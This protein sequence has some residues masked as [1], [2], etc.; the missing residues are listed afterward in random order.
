M[1]ME[2]EFDNPASAI[3][4]FGEGEFGLESVGAAFDA[5]LARGA[6]VED[7][8]DAVETAR[9]EGVIDEAQRAQLDR[10]IADSMTVY[11]GD[12]T[13]A[14]V[15]DTARDPRA[16]DGDRAESRTR[17]APPPQRGS[18]EAP[19]IGPGSRLRDR[20]II[21]E[22]LG[23]GGMGTVY[24][25][26]DGLKL[27]ARDRN[28]YLAIKVLNDSFARRPDAFIALQREASRQQRLAHPN[29]ATVFDFD[30]SGGTMFITMELLE[31]RTLDRF[32]RS[33]VRPR[34]GLP[35][36]RAMPIIEQMCAAL[37]H[38]HQRGIVHADFKPGNCF[39]TDHGELKVLD[40]GIARAMKDPAGH[41]A[42]Q[43]LF[44]PRSMGALTPAYASPEML[45]DSANADPRDDLYALGCVAYELITGMHPFK[46]VPADQAME[47]GMVPER[48]KSL[49]RR[50][51]A[52]L[53]RALAF[54][55]DARI[56][57]AE[58]FLE[59]LGS[60]RRAVSRRPVG[61]AAAGLVTV[62]LTGMF[63]VDYLRD[64]P[65]RHLRQAL[66]SQQSDAVL[67][68]LARVDEL[69]PER[70]QPILVAHRLRLLEFFEGRYRA[71]TGL[72][73]REIQFAGVQTLL[74]AAA[75]LFP[76]S[77]AVRD[78]QLD[79]E[80]LRA[81]HVSDL[82]GRF[83]R[84]L[85]PEFLVPSETG[86]DLHDLLRELAEVAPRHPLLSDVR[87][88][89][90]YAGSAQQ[91]LEAG[92]LDAAQ[93]IVDSGLML[94]VDDPALRD[95]A[96]RIGAARE[97]AGRRARIASLEDEIRAQAGALGAPGDLAQLARLRGELESLAPE[98]DALAEATAVVQA[99]ISERADAA[100][101][102]PELATVGAF[103][104]AYRAPLEA[105]GQAQILA[106]VAARWEALR[107]ERDELVERI[108]DELAGD[109][110][111]ETRR[112]TL[113]E[114]LQALARIDPEYLSRAP[115]AEEL[116]QS[117]LARAERAAMAY[118][119]A[120]ARE[121]LTL[122]RELG[123]EVD[124]VVAE[125]LADLDQRES[126]F[127]EQ[128]AAERADEAE[129]R[130]TQAVAAAEQRV[131]ERVAELQLDEAGAAALTRAA[132][133][134]QALDPGNP[135]VGRATADAAAR[136]LAGAR[137]AAERDDFDGARA[138]LDLATTFTPDAPAIAEARA[139]V[140][141][142]EVAW[143]ERDRQSRLTATVAAVKALVEPPQA[144]DSA[145][146][147]SELRRRL[148]ELESLQA[149]P[150]VLAEARRWVA[151]GY[152]QRGEALIAE[153]RFTAAARLLDLAGEYQPGT[154]RLAEARR[155]LTESRQA[156][157]AERQQ[158]ERQAEIAAGEQQFRSELASGRLDRARDIL[159]EMSALAPSGSFFEERAPALLA[160]AQ[161]RVD[162]EA[163]VVAPETAEPADVRRWLADHRSHAPADHDRLERAWLEAAA[164]RL[165]PLTG[166]P[167]SFNRTLA[168]LRAV[169]PDAG[170][171]PDPLEIAEPAPEVQPAVAVVDREALFG[172]WCSQEV[173]LEFSPESLKFLLG[174]NQEVEYPVKRYVSDGPTNIMVEWVDPRQG[175]MLMEFGDFSGDGGSMQQLRG[176]RAD[177]GSWQEYG[178]DFDR[179][180]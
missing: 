9:R 101:A 141:N 34:G 90:A 125:R 28:P 119:W 132:R 52:T 156:Y 149:E 105:L 120:L 139:Q 37:C 82:A 69:P 127:R 74:A 88:A 99:W 53:L 12:L 39:L 92:D 157:M 45:T 178:R 23:V 8:L 76:D 167:E 13:P 78:L 56:A 122:P 27:E 144:L 85:Q 130:R 15:T 41:P 49:S 118:E 83:E 65:E 2:R 58:E 142:Q 169:W 64:G 16:S 89:S 75:D 145:E 107:A 104:E 114:Q 30:R 17:M 177:D 84:F 172:R 66:A 87:V 42:D 103:L 143:R 31:G 11:A 150:A 165:A 179:C 138:L 109:E 166:D 106:P 180:G 63:A 14:G 24:R 57:S 38:A 91:A 60:R 133:Q 174:R 40:F 159:Q 47:Q 3:R 164:A 4:C 173:G 98:S 121:E 171:L 124:E 59:G 50:Q 95:I 152:L 154:G 176:K 80:R 162:I 86:E 111:V 18:A 115:L 7:L 128:L 79:F 67:E 33:E 77:A 25:G 108:R 44:D 29:I 19:R 153:K 147:Q 35:P 6:R 97:A 61:L 112:R 168:R 96:D 48:V 43:T 32:I 110:D 94:R 135:L 93:Q 123:L 117:Q 148:R 158:L 102:A 10:A 71:L 175:V 160:A 161:A 21:D 51:N 54:D 146:R 68:A 129:R 72:P 113:D 73:P 131:Q 36:D 151:D 137:Q 26:R 1:G 155:T 46:R 22:V 116:L 136:F 70:S 170:V 81:R 5:L 20:F 140:T 126:R 163:W 62:A 100:A 55:R 134:L